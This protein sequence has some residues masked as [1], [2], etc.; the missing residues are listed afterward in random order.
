MRICVAP[1]GRS[2]DLQLRGALAMRIVVAP[3]EFKG[4][5]TA[6]E[7]AAA[8]ARGARAAAPVAR[9]EEIPLSD[10]GPGLVAAVLA[11][12]LGRAVRTTVQG[13][14]GSQVE[15]VWALLE[16]GTAVIEMAS[17]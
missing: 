3:Q 12:R 6:V 15:A 10:G 17:A 2:K 1:A 9:V 11:S 16:D 13:T 14:L 7:A 4:T 8:M 5:L